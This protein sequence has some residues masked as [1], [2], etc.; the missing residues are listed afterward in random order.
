M[1]FF[2]K[3]P[4]DYSNQ[5]LQKSD[6]KYFSNLVSH[7]HDFSDENKCRNCFRKRRKQLQTNRFYLNCFPRFRSALYYVSMLSTQG[8]LKRAESSMIRYKSNQGD[9]KYE[10]LDSMRIENFNELQLV[11]LSDDC[12]EECEIE[13]EIDM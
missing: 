7:V 6:L 9:I 4:F 1:F 12:E 2:F 8:M 13:L 3:E 11:W 5:I 10:S